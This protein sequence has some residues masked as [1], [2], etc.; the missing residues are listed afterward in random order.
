MEEPAELAVEEVHKEICNIPAEQV[1]SEAV[2]A[3][4]LHTVPQTPVTG[5]LEEHMEAV[6]EMALREVREMH[7]RA[8]PYSEVVLLPV[9]ARLGVPYPMEIGIGTV[10]VLEEA[11]AGMV[12]QGAQEAHL[13]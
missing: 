2:A 6:V 7:C 9:A 4:L 5:G 10:R 8:G 12:Q 1:R 11:V 13:Q 3:L